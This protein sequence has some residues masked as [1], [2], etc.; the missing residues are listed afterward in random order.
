V[1]ILGIVVASLLMASL[2]FDTWLRLIVWLVIGMAVY[3]GYGR[4]HSR[5]ARGVAL[6]S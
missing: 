6:K 1:P 2:P 3:F 5:V 4:K